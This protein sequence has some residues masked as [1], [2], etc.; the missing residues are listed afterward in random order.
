MVVLMGIRDKELIQY[1]ISI[2]S[3]ALLQ[4]VVNCC[5]LYEATQST[6]STNH[7]SPSQLC[8]ISSYK[9]NKCQTKKDTSYWTS[10]SGHR[11]EM[12]NSHPTSVDPARFVDIDMAK[13][14][15]T[16][17]RA[18]SH[19]GH[20]G[21]AIK[22]AQCHFRSKTGHYDKCCQTRMKDNGKD[23]SEM[24]TRLGSFQATLHLGTRSCTTKIQ[25][26]EA[27]QTPLFSYAHC[28]ELA[29]VGRLVCF[30]L[31]KGTQGTKIG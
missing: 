10:A 24:A 12:P 1:L 3:R 31:P 26:H 30:F 27:I 29:I 18:C 15:A 8:T 11:K 9:R 5:C 2:D 25:V 16:L 22:N 7:S 21:N 6:T 14:S 4:N 23:G 20:W 13:G 19:Q 17:M 28:Q